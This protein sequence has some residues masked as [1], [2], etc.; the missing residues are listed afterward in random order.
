VA[1]LLSSVAAWAGSQTMGD[2]LKL[3]AFAVDLSGTRPGANTATVEISINRW[4]T[5]GERN[6]LVKTL[7]D[8]GPEALLEALRKNPPVGRIRTP[9]SLG[10]DLR[11][12][13][14]IPGA[15]GG[16]RIILLTDRPIGYWEAVNQPRSID[17]PFTLIEVRLNNE[18]TGEG[19]MSVATKI[20]TVGND[21]IALED[22]AQQPVRLQSVNVEK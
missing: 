3:R 20:T 13:H 19:K 21:T 18:G 16:R 17:Y 12:A 22:Y 2:K 7:L 9:D 11:Y 14:Q 15:D 8:K 1:G 5:D 4:S 6:R 10:Y